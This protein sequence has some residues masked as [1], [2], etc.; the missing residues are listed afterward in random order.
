MK[1]SQVLMYGYRISSAIFW[2]LI[3]MGQELEEI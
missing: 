3:M 2:K 1:G